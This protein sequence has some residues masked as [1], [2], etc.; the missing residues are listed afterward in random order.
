[1]IIDESD[2]KSSKFLK[3]ESTQPKKICHT[4]QRSIGDID[5]LSKFQKKEGS[6]RHTSKVISICTDE[7]RSPS[8]L[9]RISDADSVIYYTPEDGKCS[10]DIKPPFRFGK[11]NNGSG[12]NSLMVLENM[13]LTVYCRYCKHDVHS[14]VEAYN[15]GIPQGFLSVFSSIF[16]CCNGPL[17]FNK[18]KVHKCPRCS[19]VLGKCR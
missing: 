2:L 12:R 19:L 17:W 5:E 1:M 7:D 6:T 10:L 14:K 13:P 8:H 9:R 18:M 16:T 3:F 4:R 15:A 11:E